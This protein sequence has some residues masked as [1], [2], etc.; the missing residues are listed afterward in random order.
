MRLSFYLAVLLGIATQTV[1]ADTLSVH[2]ENIEIPEHVYNSN[3]GSLEYSTSGGVAVFDCNDDN[4]PE[5]FIAGGANLSQ[6]F[7][8]TSGENIS[9]HADTPIQLLLTGVTGA[10][11]LDIDSDGL[12]DLAIL[13]IGQDFLMRGRP[14]CSFEPFPA[15]LNFQSRHHWTTGFSATWESGQTLPTRN[16]SGSQ[17]WLFS[18]V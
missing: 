15:T 12:L 14:N 4:R 6:L 3:N 10:Y 11:P 7:I 9:F 17:T 16:Y 1:A 13:R 8:N 5:L 18:G 2:F